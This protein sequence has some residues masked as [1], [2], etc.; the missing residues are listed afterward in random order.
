LFH[1]KRKLHDE[2]TTVIFKEERTTNE[3]TISTNIRMERGTLWNRSMDHRKS[4]PENPRGLR[5]LVLGENAEDQIDKIRNEEVYRRLYEV[6][7]LWDTT[8][9]SRTRWIGHT[10]RQN[11][12][13]KN[14]IERK[15]E[16]KVPRGRPRDKCMG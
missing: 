6:R 3:E 4:R 11:G 5:N 8:E 14:I 1:F 16:G 9:K 10:L 7:T 12:F 13:A 2:K 15:I